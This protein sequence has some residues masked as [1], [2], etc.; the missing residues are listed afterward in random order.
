M[1]LNFGRDSEPTFGQYF[2]VDF[3]AYAWSRFLR[4]NLIKICFWTW[5]SSRARWRLDSGHTCEFP[6]KTWS[7]L[8]PVRDS[9]LSSILVPFGF[10]CCPA[11]F[12]EEMRATPNHK[13]SVSSPL[14]LSA[15]H[16]RCVGHA[17]CHGAQPALPC[18]MQ[19]WWS[20]TVSR[21]GGWPNG[22]SGAP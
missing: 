21:L 11:P 10:L 20:W 19:L 3:E 4:W 6:P 9:I 5:V 12:P 1:K 14:L 2:G 8:F 18:P 22:A 16:K 15:M 17:V 7:P 13:S